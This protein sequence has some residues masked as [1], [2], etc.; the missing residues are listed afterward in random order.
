MTVRTADTD[1]R[2]DSS[3]PCRAAGRREVQVH[4]LRDCGS[5]GKAGID[6]S[7]KM[8]LA[9]DQSRRRPLDRVSFA[10]TPRAMPRDP[11]A[12]LQPS[13]S[14]IRQ[15]NRI[16]KTSSRIGVFA[17]S[18]AAA[19]EWKSVIL[20]PRHLSKLGAVAPG[21]LTRRHARSAQLVGERHGE[22]V[23]NPWSRSTSCGPG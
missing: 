5:R 23:T 7:F 2:G 18:V 21:Q 10:A 4:V 15:R 1:G 16:Q 11:K 20:R 22:R 9:A 12:E 14:A 8:S 19:A 13:L 6:G 3:P 17:T